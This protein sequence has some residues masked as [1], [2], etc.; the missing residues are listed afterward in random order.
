MAGFFDKEL[1]LKNWFSDEI[2]GWFDETL[3]SVNQVDVT[4]ALTGTAITAATGTQTPGISEDLTGINLVGATGTMVADI[5]EPV[6]KDL[7]GTGMTAATGTLIAQVGEALTGINI[8]GAQGTIVSGNEKALTGTN[9]GG[10]QGSITEE[11]SYGLSGSQ[12]NFAAGTLTADIGGSDVTRP[13]TGENLTGAQ[14]S[15]GVDVTREL[16]GIGITSGDGV[17]SAGHSLALNG[18]SITV[19]AGS[20]FSV[21]HCDFPVFSPEYTVGYACASEYVVITPAQLLMIADTWRRLGL[22]ANYPLSES[23]TAATFG[24]V[25]ITKTGTTTVTSTRSGTG[26]TPPTAAVMLSDI[27]KRLGLDADNPMTVTA[28]QITAGS[29]I[30]SIE[31]AGGVTTVTRQ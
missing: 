6:T 29:L 27:Y 3:I 10:A 21:E 17:I 31:T 5:N 8:T 13:L 25:T 20:I 23:A 26:A 1:A 2:A 9:L 24:A 7:T 28:S 11:L 22:D 14:G 16:T 12:S 19:E 15:F 18:S 4:K 30:Q